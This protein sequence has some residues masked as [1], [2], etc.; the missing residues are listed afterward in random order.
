[1]EIKPPSAAPNFFS[2]WGTMA[3]GV[4]QGSILGPL[5][6]VSYINNL[7]PTIKTLLEPIIFTDFISVI[8]TNNNFYDFCS[9][10]NSVLPRMGKWFTANELALVFDKTKFIKFVTN[11]LPQSALRIAYKRKYIQQS[12]NTKFLSLQTD[13][14]LN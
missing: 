9:L 13:N 5:L 11:N 6:F 10:A 7:P 1:V 4:S 8:I 12:A 3:H 2:N 14:H